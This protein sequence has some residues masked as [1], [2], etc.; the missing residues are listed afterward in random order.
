MSD[1]SVAAPETF[2]ARSTHLAIYI[3]AANL[4]RY[5]RAEQS[6]HA[7]VFLFDDPHG[8]GADLER[9]WRAGI[10]QLVNPK[11]ILD[12]RNKIIDEIK[13]VQTAD[14]R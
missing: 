6:E 1:T 8:Q 11:I 13:R 9:A 3:I 12:V 2:V 4:L 7:V 10:V 5:L 14:V